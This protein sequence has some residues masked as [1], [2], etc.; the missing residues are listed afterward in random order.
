MVDQRFLS[1]WSDLILVWQRTSCSWAKKIGG[2][3]FRLAIFFQPCG[4]GSRFSIRVARF[5]THLAVVAQVVSRTG[6]KSRKT[7]ETIS[8]ARFLLPKG[9]LLRESCQ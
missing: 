9:L 3:S 8:G 4:G 2:M 5:R 6:T 7:V 1:D